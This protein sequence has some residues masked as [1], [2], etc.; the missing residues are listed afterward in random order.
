MIVVFGSINLDLIFHV[1]QRPA[2]GETVLA[3]AARLEPG[4]KGANQAMAAALDGSQVIMAGA[5]GRDPLASLALEGMR[6]AGI[7]LTRVV[8]A[9]A[10]TGCAS[11]TTD[12]SGENAISVGSGANLLARAEQIEDALLGPDT[13]LIVQMETAPEETAALLLRARARGARSVLNLAP[14]AMLDPAALRATDLLVVNKNEAAWLA[15]RIGSGANASSLRSA[16]GIDVV[17]TMGGEGA[18]LVTAEGRYR[19][20]EMPVNALDT[21]AAGDCFT[22][23]LAATLDR[24]G[25]MDEAMRRAS[26]AAALC[27]T[28]LG[29]QSSL[30]T[31][32]ETE[33]ALREYQAQREEGMESD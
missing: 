10:V 26:V 22:G 4:G 21:T 29:S 14:A 32:A 2:P 1:H 16:L 9:D 11:I 27:C 7:D 31:R 30:P 8:E 19:Y 20:A 6:R 13:T 28:R 3:R 24:G 23:V 5:V 18:E 12:G 25:S 15:T 33:T 17:R